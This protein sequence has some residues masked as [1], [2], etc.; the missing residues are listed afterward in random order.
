MI[1][2]PKVGKGRFLGVLA[3]ILLGFLPI[4]INCNCCMQLGRVGFL[5]CLC[6]VQPLN[7][8]KLLQSENRKFGCNGLQ[9]FC[10]KP[11]DLCG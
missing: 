8:L 7:L 2:G 9:F 5:K 1:A 3:L 4:A 10:G 6:L 11:V